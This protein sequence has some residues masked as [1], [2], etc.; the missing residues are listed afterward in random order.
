MGHGCRKYLEEVLAA[1]LKLFLTV[2]YHRQEAAPPPPQPPVVINRYSDDQLRSI[3]LRMR[4]RHQLFKDK[5]LDHY[6]SSP[7]ITPPVSE[8]QDGLHPGGGQGARLH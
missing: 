8:Y 1:H 5:V 6:A 3:I 7:E 4:E 2:V